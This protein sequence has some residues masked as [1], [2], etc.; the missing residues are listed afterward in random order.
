MHGNCGHAEIL[1]TRRRAPVAESSKHSKAQRVVFCCMQENTKQAMNKL[2]SIVIWQ[3]LR[4]VQNRGSRFGL[5]AKM[6][7]A[8]S[9]TLQTQSRNTR[10]FKKSWVHAV[11]T[12][13]P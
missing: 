8:V 13:L 5:E 10:Y 7:V 3:C 2:L 12:N 4:H 11:I 6:H 9:G 1:C